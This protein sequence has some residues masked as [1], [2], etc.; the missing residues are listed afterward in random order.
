MASSDDDHSSVSMGRN[1][2]MLRAE[3][4]V[5]Q[6]FI[7]RDICVSNLHTRLSENEDKRCEYSK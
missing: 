7:R 3:Y 6:M 2:S 4:I 1:I 5:K